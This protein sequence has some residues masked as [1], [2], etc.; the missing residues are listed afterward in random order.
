MSNVLELTGNSQIDEF[1]V[2]HGFAD[3]APFPNQ[4]PYQSYHAPADTIDPNLLN[5][6]TTTTAP[7]EQQLFDNTYSESHDTLPTIASSASSVFNAPMSQYT[8]TE[9]S[10]VVDKLDQILNIVGLEGIFPHRRLI[11]ITDPNFAQLLQPIFTVA[12]TLAVFAADLNLA[13]ADR[14]D[15]LRIL[16]DIAKK[17]WQIVQTAYHAA[18]PNKDLEPSKF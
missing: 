3:E 15:V 6:F 2:E 9:T 16:Y 12:K 14:M 13:G 1:L 7:A 8:A 18:K 17:A 5:I 11:R 10:N 4:Y